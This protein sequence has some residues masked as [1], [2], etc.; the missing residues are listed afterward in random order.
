MNE[1]LAEVQVDHA[2][3]GS[4]VDALVAQL[5]KALKNMSAAQASAVA[6]T[7]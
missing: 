5:Q 2:A 4:V 6:V 3:V 7:A 1:L